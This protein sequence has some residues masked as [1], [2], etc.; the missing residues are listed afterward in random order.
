[1][2]KQALKQ[3]EKPA[4]HCLSGLSSVGG[5]HRPAPDQAAAQL[6]TCLPTCNRSSSLLAQPVCSRLKT[7]RAHRLARDEAQKAQVPQAQ[8]GSTD[9]HTHSAVTRV[10]RRSVWLRACARSCSTHVAHALGVASAAQRAALH[11]DARA[12]QRSPPGR[13]GSHRT[14]ASASARAGQFALYRGIECSAERGAPATKA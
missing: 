12:S 4:V 8:A 7:F 11:K 14:G 5:Q 13:S 3:H 2:C 10:G 9:T 6:G 1:M